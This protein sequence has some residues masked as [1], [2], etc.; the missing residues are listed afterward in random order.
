M[1]YDY[2]RLLPDDLLELTQ[3]DI[4]SELRLSIGNEGIGTCERLLEKCGVLERLEPD[5][6]MAAVRIESELPTLVDL[7]PRQAAAQRTVLRAWNSASPNAATN[8][9]TSTRTS[10]P[11]RSTCR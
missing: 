8:W 2:L 3:E 5:R 4:K 6:N 7:L 1:V 9:S 10:L 11:S